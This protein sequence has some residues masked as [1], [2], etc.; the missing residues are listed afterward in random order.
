[1]IYPGGKKVFSIRRIVPY[2][3]VNGHI[4]ELKEIYTS[5]YASVITYTSRTDIKHRVQPNGQINL[6]F[7]A[8]FGLRRYAPDVL[9]AI[10]TRIVDASLHTL[11]AKNHQKIVDDKL[12][13]LDEEYDKYKRMKP[14][15]KDEVC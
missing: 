14:K 1:M 11:Y 5:L 3:M 8:T 2:K 13:G 10:I 9:K 12:N 7:T 6:V 15:F 4:T